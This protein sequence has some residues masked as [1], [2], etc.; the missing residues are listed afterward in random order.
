MKMYKIFAGLV[1]L[2]LVLPLPGCVSGDLT[3]SYMRE[4]TS[5]AHIEAV[6]VMPFEG[7]GRAPRIRELTMT[8]LLASGLFEVVD[9]GRV[10]AFLQQEAIAPGTPL[11]NFTIKRLG[12]SL[13]VK[14]L[15]FGSVEQASE[16]RG[17]AR[18]PEMIMTLRL[19]DTE[20]GLLLWQASGRGSGYSL[21]D[22]L[23]GFSPKDSFEVTL[24]LLNSLFMTMR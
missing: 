22:R 21:A 17:N 14:A 13:K 12:E 10:D 16:T 4:N 1:L 15:L 20:T 24:E 3:Q 6:A 11:D 5:L 7:G 19:I 18:F 23:F 9:K 8:Q 2:G